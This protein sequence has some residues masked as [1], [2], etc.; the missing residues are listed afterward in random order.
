MSTSTTFLGLINPDGDDPFSRAVLNG[1]NDTIDKNM[2]AL[3][4]SGLPY[5]N[6]TY[7][8]MTFDSN[9]DPQIQSFSGANGLTG[10][11]AWTWGANS[12][13]KTFSITAPTAFSVVETVNLD[14][15]AKT[16]EVS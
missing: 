9:G 7:G 14:T 5:A 6:L 2:I 15:F 8:A 1:N 13:T 12:V 10:S 4:F 3:V 16:V 11:I